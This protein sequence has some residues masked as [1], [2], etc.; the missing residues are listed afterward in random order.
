MWDLTTWALECYFFYLLLF[1]TQT[2]T[3]FRGCALRTHILAITD[4]CPPSVTSFGLFIRVFVMY[5]PKT[6]TL[7]S[8]FQILIPLSMF[9][10]LISFCPCD[11]RCN[12][13][14]NTTSHKRVSG[15][16][17]HFCTWLGHHRWYCHGWSW[18][19][20]MSASRWQR[21]CG[22]GVWRGVH[23]RNID[24]LQFIYPTCSLDHSIPYSLISQPG[25]VV[26][27]QIDRQLRKDVD[28]CIHRHNTHTTSGMSE[29]F[30]DPRCS[31][32][33]FKTP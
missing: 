9:S 5:T 6:F 17:S 23:C 21:D 31:V 29:I 11:G 33:F 19:W 30:E 20:G 28:T 7:D 22:R 16:R 2:F 14:D 18:T 4:S 24:S 12:P 10:L 27:A 26:R 8:L 15:G 13:T 25:S 3:S 1:F 32:L